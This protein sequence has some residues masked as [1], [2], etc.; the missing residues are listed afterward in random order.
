MRHE[1]TFLK[2]SHHL[3]SACNITLPIVLPSCQPSCRKMYGDGGPFSFFA[4]SAAFLSSVISCVSALRGLPQKKSNIYPHAALCLP[5]PLSLSPR[6]P[7][8]CRGFTSSPVTGPPTSPSGSPP[9]AGRDSQG[10]DRLGRPLTGSAPPPPQPA[11]A[12]VPPTSGANPHGPS[13]LSLLWGANSLTRPVGLAGAKGK[14]SHPRSHQPLSGGWT[15]PCPGEGP[16]S[17]V[18]R[19]F[20]SPGRGPAMPMFLP[21][22]LSHVE[23]IKLTN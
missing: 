2:E 13:P 17:G 1:R 4:N 14:T 6:A 3:L 16:P 7:G 9:P 15:H 5:P 12:L 20:P 18:R 22:A 21:D 10:G 19:L 8:R 11:F 23:G